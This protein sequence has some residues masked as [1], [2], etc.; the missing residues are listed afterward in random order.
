VLRKKLGDGSPHSFFMFFANSGETLTIDNVSLKPYTPTAAEL[1]AFNDAS[2]GVGGIANETAFVATLYD[3]AST[4]DATQSTSTAQPKLITAGVTELE[5]GK[6]AMVFDGTDDNL[7]FPNSWSGG[8]LSYSIVS[9][10]DA[11]GAADGSVLG[12]NNTDVVWLLSNRGPTGGSDAVRGLGSSWDLYGNGSQVGT[13]GS[14]TQANLYSAVGTSQALQT[15]VNADASGS[16][17][18]PYD[19]GEYSPDSRFNH[20]GTIQE[21]IIYASDQ[22]SNRTILETNINDHYGIY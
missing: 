7:E 8:T 12:Y 18:S 4:N 9:K 6:P 22:T 13:T 19:F 11:A 10:L 15:V 16:V 5:N 2:G 20:L 14:A 21:I 17:S 1:W 3:Q